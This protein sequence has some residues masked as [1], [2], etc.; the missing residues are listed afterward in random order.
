MEY[1]PALE[2][3]EFLQD[4]IEVAKTLVKLKQF[5]KALSLLSQLETCP[6]VEYLM[7]ECH[8]HM[9]NIDDAFE[10]LKKGVENDKDKQLDFYRYSAKLKAFLQ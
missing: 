3:F 10:H 6:Q 1:M 7:Y 4:D 5:E 9:G 8:T 2:M